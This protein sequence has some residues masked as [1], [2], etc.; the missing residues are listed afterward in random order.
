MMMMMMI[1]SLLTSTVFIKTLNVAVVEKMTVGD[2]ARPRYN[3]LAVN[4]L[5]TDFMYGHLRLNLIGIH[6]IVIHE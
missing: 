5:K 6:E 2:I 3:H 1:S 4:A